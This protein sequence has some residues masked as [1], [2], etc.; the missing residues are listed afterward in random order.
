MI[1]K[2][3]IK[4]ALIVSGENAGPLIDQTLQ[5]LLNDPTMDRKKIKP[6]MASLTIGSAAVAFLLTHSSLAPDAPKIVGGSTLT[7][8]GSVE[9]CQGDGSTEG[10]MMATDSEALLKAGVKLA[11]ENWEKAKLVL[12]WTNDDV[13]K[14]IKRVLVRSSDGT[15][16]D[17]GLSQL[18][19]G[20]WRRVSM[21]LD[22]AFVE[23]I[24][25][26]GT[27]RSNILVM[28][29]VLTH[30]DGAGREAVGTVLRAMVDGEK[31]SS[32][33]FNS[34]F[35]GIN[36]NPISDG[37]D[38]PTVDSDVDDY[39]S[40]MYEMSRQL[41]GGGAYETVIVILQDLAAV[42]LEEAFDHIDTVVKDSDT[43][44]VIIDG[45]DM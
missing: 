1:E 29:E 36:D 24:R 44:R 42:E 10:L 35:S 45:E 33:N 16:K 21:A 6:Y 43:S 17:R 7:D 40:T 20:Q 15:F 19:G 38:Q 12:G 18:S 22:L 14:I 28:D 27:L 30:L 41:L 39:K 23:V 31:T 34:S 32:S 9:L 4:T 5:H 26:R 3:V 11:S 2:G 25:R 13:D 37:D 8:S